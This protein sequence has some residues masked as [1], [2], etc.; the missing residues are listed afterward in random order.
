MGAW[1]WGTC[2]CCCKLEKRRKKKKKQTR[3]EKGRN[4]LAGGIFPATPHHRQLAARPTSKIIRSRNGVS[5]V[6]HCQKQAI[7]Y[8]F[9]GLTSK[10]RAR[11]PPLPT[12]PPR[13]IP[14]VSNSTLVPH[15]QFT[16]RSTFINQKPSLVGPERGPCPKLRCPPSSRKQQREAKFGVV[17]QP[18]QTTSGPTPVLDAKPTVQSSVLG[19]GPPVKSPL[20]VGK[21]SGS[22]PPEQ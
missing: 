8:Y 7:V 5:M 18:T 12:L 22:D 21:S 15:T 17:F 13:P 2:C 3:K 9:S 10:F 11:T 20:V 16:L 6:R 1:G 19:K 4:P 14:A